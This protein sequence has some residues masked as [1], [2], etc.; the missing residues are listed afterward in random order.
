[1]REIDKEQTEAEIYIFKLTLFYLEYFLLYVTF[2]FP[3]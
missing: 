2:F 3:F 1:M